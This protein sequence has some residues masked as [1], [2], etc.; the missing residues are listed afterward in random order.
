M[1]TQ[2]I[3]DQKTHVMPDDEKYL[4]KF[5]MTCDCNPKLDEGVVVHSGFSIRRRKW[6]CSSPRS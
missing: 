3:D 2:N 1:A 5:N 4:H 6:L